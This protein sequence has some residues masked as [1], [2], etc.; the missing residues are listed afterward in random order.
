MSLKVYILVPD[1]PQNNHAIF[2]TKLYAKTG[3]KDVERLLTVKIA[4]IEIVQ[5]LL[6]LWQ[7]IAV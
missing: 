5:F 4:A 7:L 2:H 3:K 1:H 6:M